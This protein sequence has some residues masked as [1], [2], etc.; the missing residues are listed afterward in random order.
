MT[1]LAEFDREGAQRAVRYEPLYALLAK[2]Q[3]WRELRHRFGSF[4]RLEEEIAAVY[5]DLNEE[6]S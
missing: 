3:V 2:R 5:A 1:L 4:E 6:E